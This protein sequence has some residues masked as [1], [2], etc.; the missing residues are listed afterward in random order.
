MKGKTK[1][2]G[3][4]SRKEEL[5]RVVIKL[6]SDEG[7]ESLGFESVGARAKM[8][9][10]HVAYYFKSKEEML[11][12]AILQMTR[13]A[14]TIT[15]E[16]LKKYSDPEEKVFGVVRGAFVWVKKF[17][18]QPG[19]LFLLYHLAFASES[20]RVL[21][22]SI[23]ATGWDRLGVLLSEIPRF[24]E[25]PFSKLKELAIQVQALITGN[26]VN[27][28]ATA[29]EHDFEYWSQLTEAGVRQLLGS[30]LLSDATRR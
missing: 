5:L 13:D 11:R 30:P 26:I 17:P 25:F 7:I 14:Q 18:E 12:E 21:H 9:R 19:L 1:K 16:E 24:R 15:I 3:A 29:S 22:T 23:R 8:K 28:C 6:L 27:A 20:Y 4:E 10:A 2:T